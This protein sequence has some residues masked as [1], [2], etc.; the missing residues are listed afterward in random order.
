GNGGEGSGSDGSTAKQH[1]DSG[2]GSAQFKAKGGDNSVQE[3]GSEASGSEFDQAAAAVHGFF[4]ARVR[5]DWE[6]ACSYLA[7][8]VSKSLQQLGGKSDELE[9]AGCAKTLE[10]ISEGV[11]ASAFKEAAKADIG[12]LRVDGDQAF[13]IYVGAQQVVLAMPMKDEDGTWKV[14]SLAGTPLS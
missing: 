1:D 12:S 14:A 6:A 11:P 4:D 3:F 2:G 7:A 9:A 5:G 13:V 8:D 10:A